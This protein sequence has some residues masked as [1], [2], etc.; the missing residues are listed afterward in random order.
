MSYDLYLRTETPRSTVR[1]WFAQ[2][3]YAVNTEQ[4]LYENDNTGVYFTFWLSEEGGKTCAAFNLNYFRPDIFALEAAP[5]L[6]A[7]IRNFHASIED[8]QSEGM[9]DGPYSAEGFLRGWNAGNG[10]AAKVMVDRGA[11]AVALPRATNQA[12]WMW[13]VSREAYMDLLGSIEM[14]GVFV[15]TAM[16]MEVDG[17]PCTAVIWGEAMPIALP[18]VDW[19]ISVGPEEDQAPKWIR[20]AEIEGLLGAA[21]QREDYTFELDGGKWFTGF[22]HHLVEKPSPELVAA[23]NEK[24]VDLEA[25]RLS[26][27]DVLDAELF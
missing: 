5:E 2:R 3:G 17:A 7:F 14:I 22:S 23:L 24:G 6:A 11:S 19:I 1:T 21:V 26:P 15:P 25:E 18:H 12:V 4:A 16:I 20:Y 10:F 9:G 13:N 27:G 8:P